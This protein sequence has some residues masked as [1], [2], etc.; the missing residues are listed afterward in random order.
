MAT[1]GVNFVETSYKDAQRFLQAFERA[2][3]AS[4]SISGACKH[5]G[6]TRRWYYNQVGSDC[7]IG[8]GLEYIVKNA[9]ING[10]AEKQPRRKVN[11]RA[12][13]GTKYL[14]LIHETALDCYKIGVATDVSARFAVMDSSC[15]QDM[16]VVDSVMV[17]DAYEKEEELHLRYLGKRVKGEW[18]ALDEHDVKEII[19]HFRKWEEKKSTQPKMS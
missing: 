8:R 11:R 3:I 12:R 6:I 17:N 5:I 9:R 18:F 14:Y 2:L 10:D 13:H 7:E 15:P 4:G 19:T 16:Q 1:R